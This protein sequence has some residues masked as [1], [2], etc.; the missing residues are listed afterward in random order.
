MTNQDVRGSVTNI[1]DGDDD[2]VKSYTY[3][4]YGKTSGAG[5]FVNSFAYT[6]A[7]NP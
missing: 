7:V 1:V 3:E 6:G 5:N 4:A 2:V